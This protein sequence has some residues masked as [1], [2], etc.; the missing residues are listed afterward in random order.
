MS[1]VSQDDRVALTLTAFPGIEIKHKVRVAAS[2][3][4][5]LG[6]LGLGGQ[7]QELEQIRIPIA[8]TYG[9]PVGSAFIRFDEWCTDP[10]TRIFC[11][12]E[13]ARRI[14]AYSVNEGVLETANGKYNTKI[15]LEF[16]YRV[17]MTRE[18]DRNNLIGGGG[19]ANLQVN[20]KQGAEIPPSSSDVPAPVSS[21]QPVDPMAPASNAGLAA[22]N[23]R[24]V[25][26]HE[27]FQRPLVF[28]YRAIRVGLI[29]S[30]P[31]RASP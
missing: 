26:I 16:V 15:A 7:D 2:F 18:I 31:G 27:V 13:Y 22:A 5:G 28:G 19:G 8:E 23:S 24:E 1:D 10:K 4:L 25:A 20:A 9:A 30:T 17:F 21:V 3:G 29:P 6:A 12:D 14:M 11:T